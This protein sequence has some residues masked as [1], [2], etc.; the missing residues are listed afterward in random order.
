MRDGFPFPVTFS[1]GGP[2]A[3]QDY[4]DAINRR[5]WARYSCQGAASGCGELNVIGL[6]SIRRVLCNYFDLHPAPPVAV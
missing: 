4:I 2:N 5:R 6:V 3:R 1:P